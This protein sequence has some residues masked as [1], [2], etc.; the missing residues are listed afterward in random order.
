MEPELSPGYFVLGLTLGATGKYEDA[1]QTMERAAELQ[2]P[3]ME[4]LCWLAHMQAVAGHREEA[5]RILEDVLKRRNEDS[6]F[7]YGVAVIYTGL[8]E[9]DEAFKWLDAAVRVRDEWATFIQADFRLDPLR[10][11]PRYRDLVRRMGFE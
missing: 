8:G 1:I 4:N 5:R 10:A 11:D 3:S 2:G 7:N 6:F 9:P